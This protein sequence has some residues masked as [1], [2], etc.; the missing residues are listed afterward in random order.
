MT[1][2]QRLL[3]YKRLPSAAMQHRSDWID[4][5]RATDIH[6]DCCCEGAWRKWRKAWK[7]L[8]PADRQQYFDQYTLGMLIRSVPS[9]QPIEDSGVALTPLTQ[10]QSSIIFPIRKSKTQKTKIKDMPNALYH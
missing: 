5:Q 6:F 10:A 2:E 1:I 8:L 4:T 7:F 9:V 3:L